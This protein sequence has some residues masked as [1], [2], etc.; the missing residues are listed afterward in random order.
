MV[1]GQANDDEE[2]QLAPPAEVAD[3]MA[4]MD[5]YQQQPMQSREKQAINHFNRT[6]DEIMVIIIFDLTQLQLCVRR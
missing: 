1:T 6:T 4:V 2:G 3:E 5:V